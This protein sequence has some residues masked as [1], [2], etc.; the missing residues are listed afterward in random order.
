M[1][2]SLNMEVSNQEIS[3]LSKLK[4]MQG[5]CVVSKQQFTSSASL[6]RTIFSYRGPV[7]TSIN[8]NYLRNYTG[9]ILGSDD[10]PALLNATHNHGK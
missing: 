7:K 8:A 2:L 5:S 4:S 3:M 9:G 6:T 10:D 1:L